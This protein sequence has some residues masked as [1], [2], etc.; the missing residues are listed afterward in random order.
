[1]DGR[2]L[3]FPGPP[4][5]PGAARLSV[6]RRQPPTTTPTRL[7]GS[8]GRPQLDRGVPLR[9]QTSRAPATGGRP[10]GGT[11]PGAS[12]SRPGAR[13]ALWEGETRPKPGTAT[14]HRRK[15]SPFGGIP[16]PSPPAI[17]RS[18]TW[19]RRASTGGA[20]ANHGP[21]GRPHRAGTQ[22]QARERLVTTRGKAAEGNNL[23][24]HPREKRTTEG[25]RA[26]GGGQRRA[27]GGSR[28]HPPREDMVTMRATAGGTGAHHAT[29]QA[30]PQGGLA[31]TFPGVTGPHTQ[32]GTGVTSVAPHGGRGGV[33]Q[34]GPDEA[35]EGE[36]AQGRATGETRGTVQ[37]KRALVWLAQAACQ[38]GP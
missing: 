21:N 3:R 35:A 15:A 33:G 13:P 37:T 12:A 38:D 4:P 22:A 6:G 26:I 7:L 36:A 23:R 5:P 2:R 31:R 11:P 10:Q 24:T 32:G 1:M 18:V 28:P 19:T 17:T 27:A 34:A 25:A 14:L 20:M 16:I 8:T 29:A 30:L 9:E